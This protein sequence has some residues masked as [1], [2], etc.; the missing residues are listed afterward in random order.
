MICYFDAFQAKE[1]FGDPL[2]SREVGI[3][4]VE[5]LKTYQDMDVSIPCFTYTITFSWTSH[6]TL[7]TCILDTTAGCLSGLP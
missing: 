6:R 4:G 1:H 2:E 7:L 5:L 3:N